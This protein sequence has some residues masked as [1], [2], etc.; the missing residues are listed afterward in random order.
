MLEE[1]SQCAALILALFLHTHCLLPQGL[2]EGSR[3][4]IGIIYTS[5]LLL[6]RSGMLD[7]SRNF[8]YLLFWVW[9]FFVGFFGFFSEFSGFFSDLLEVLQRAEWP[10][11]SGFK[12]FLVLTQQVRSIIATWHDNSN[13]NHWAGGGKEHSL[14]H[15]LSF[16]TC[17]SRMR[18]EQSLIL[19]SSKLQTS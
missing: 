18:M 17:F 4:T 3:W 15:F 2:E 5:P 1:E 12:K 11:N 13:R 10:L 7:P 6:A 16:E 9:G 8:N 14:L 19:V